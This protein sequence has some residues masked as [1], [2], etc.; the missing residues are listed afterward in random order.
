M[1]GLTPQNFVFDKKL[2]VLPHYPRG[3]MGVD[4][5][6]RPIYI[7]RSGMVN[8]TPIWEICDEEYLFK[9]YYQ[10]YEVLIKQ[11]FMVCSYLQQKQIQQTFSILDMTGFSVSM[12]NSKVKG[13]VQ[14]V[15]K[16]AQDYYPEQLG[17][18][19]ICNAPMLFTG[20]WAIV[21][22]WLDERTRQK[23]QIHGG[24]YTK[25]LLEYVDEDQLADFLGGKNTAKL[26]DD[27]GP[28]ND[29]DIVDGAEAGMT[30]G[31]AKKGTTEVIFSAED[32]M[33]LPNYKQSAVAQYTGGEESKTGE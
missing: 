12:M 10:S 3:Y 32:L 17:Q 11:H 18:L 27:F 29:Y 30:V 23:I 9:S 14:K 20:I 6:G 19:M 24:G 25:K 31:I 8:P 7:E 16:I 13:L 22:V 1:P 26:E 28:W 2:E 4:K 33:K 5:M 21:K 15:S